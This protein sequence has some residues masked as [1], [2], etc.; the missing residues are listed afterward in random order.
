[1]NLCPCIYVFFSTVS[2]KNL[3]SFRLTLGGSLL[4]ENLNPF[5]TIFILSMFT[6]L[7]LSDFKC[8]EALE[9][10]LNS[11]LFPS[12][13]NKT[14]LHIFYFSLHQFLFHLLHS[15]TF[16]RKK[17]HSG[18]MTITEK[19]FFIFLT[20][21]LHLSLLIRSTFLTFSLLWLL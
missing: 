12:L 18:P 13:H 15:I 11:F 19:K 21:L 6:S 4:E 8:T 5:V 10:L 2:E 3:P 9:P 1:M 16:S 20:I 7:F 14:W 17:Y